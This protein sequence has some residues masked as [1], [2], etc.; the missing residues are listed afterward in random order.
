MKAVTGAKLV[1]AEGILENHILIHDEVIRGIIPKTELSDLCGMAV[2]EADGR[3]LSPGFIDI[4]HHGCFGADVMDGTRAALATIAEALPQFGVTAFL[5]TTMTQAP[6]VIA[7]AV[8]AVGSWMRQP[9]SGAEVLGVHLEGPFI[10]PR[11]RGA[12][13]AAFIL[14]PDYAMVAP[15]L[16]AIRLIT[17]APECLGAQGFIAQVQRHP[18]VVL[19]IGHSDAT[20]EEALEAY[21]WGVRHI[22]HCFNAM[23]P[24]HH[25]APGV[26]GAALAWPF[27]TEL[28]CDDH[29]INPAFYQ[30]FINIKGAE[31]TILVSDCIRAGGLPGGTA[32]LGGQTVTVSEGI[33]RLS[34]GT[35]A[36]ST[37]TLNTA[38]DNVR[39][40]TELPLDRLVAMASANPARLLGLEH[41]KGALAVGLDADCVLHDEDFRVFRTWGRGKIIYEAGELL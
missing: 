1:T 33:C 37:L 20:Y 26:V 11:Y 27:T 23:S 7:Q 4:H 13:N 5:P 24:L 10:S 34:D 16:E 2:S 14:K 40:R 15:W 18:H 17:L 32:H 28:I 36:G 31:R 39:R 6:A 9:G 19:A 30:G 3:F 21:G 29:H 8:A 35:L 38:L 12:Q 22:T 25:R 41:R